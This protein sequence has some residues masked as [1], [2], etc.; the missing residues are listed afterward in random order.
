MEL[1][2]GLILLCTFVLVWGT[3]AA[4]NWRKERLRRQ[5]LEQYIVNLLA[6]GY[7][8]EDQAEETEEA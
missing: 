4:Y 5:V 1:Q 6:K 3:F 2:I 7:G 8:K